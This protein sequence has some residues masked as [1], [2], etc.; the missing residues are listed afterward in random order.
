MLLQLIVISNF[1]RSEEYINFTMMMC[2]LLYFGVVKI[3][4]S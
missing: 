1:K 3:L 4:Q 2:I